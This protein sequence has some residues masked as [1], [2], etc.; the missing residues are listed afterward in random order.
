MGIFSVTTFNVSGVTVTKNIN[1]LARSIADV[2]R[3]ILVWGVGVIITVTAGRTYP[4]Y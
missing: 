4:N 1:A 2:T 3:T